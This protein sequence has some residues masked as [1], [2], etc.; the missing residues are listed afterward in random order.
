[1]AGHGR[2]LACVAL[3]V[4]RPFQ[5][6]LDL[7]PS[8][9]TDQTGQDVGSLVGLGLGLALGCGLWGAGEAVRVMCVG[10]RAG[11]DGEQRHLADHWMASRARG[12]AAAALVGDAA[13]RGRALVTL[14]QR[15]TV[16]ATELEAEAD[17]ARRAGLALGLRYA[18]LAACALGAV[19]R[20]LCLERRPVVWGADTELRVRGRSDEA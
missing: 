4:V 8:G 9:N 17:A 12:G 15:A 6:A 20:T 18:C 1:M 14:V 19:A 16:L 10:D 13:A 3:N 11:C 2:L 7:R 5:Y